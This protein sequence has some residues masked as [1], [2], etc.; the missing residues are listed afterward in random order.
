M[1]DSNIVASVLV[2]SLLPSLWLLHINVGE[3]RARPGRSPAFAAQVAA[4]VFN[5]VNQTIF[6]VLH[7]AKAASLPGSCGAWILI[8]DTSYVLFQPAATGVLVL[9]STALIPSHHRVWW[10]SRRGVRAMLALVF[11]IG[12]SPIVVSVAMRD[13][14]VDSATGLCFALYPL[15]INTAGKIVFVLLYMA[16]GVVF[17]LPLLRHLNA[18]QR[19]SNTGP[20]AT[21]T[22]LRRVL[23]DVAFRISL[24]IVGYLLTAVIS[25][26]GGFTGAVSVEF[27]LQNLCALGAATFA[28]RS[29]NYDSSGGG[30]NGTNTG[31]GPSETNS[32]RPLDSSTVGAGSSTFDDPAR[33]RHGH[34]RAGGA[35]NGSSAGLIS[36]PGYYSMTSSQGMPLTPLSGGH[37]VLVAPEVKSPAL[38][39][40]ALASPAAHAHQGWR[41]PQPPQHHQGVIP[42]APPSP[43]PAS[44]SLS[45]GRTSPWRTSPSPSRG[46]LLEAPAPTARSGLPPPPPLIGAAPPPRRKS[47]APSNTSTSH[48]SK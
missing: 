8:A 9:R 40:P 22:I 11:L 1:W 48:L 27:T 20:A 44:P 32:R 12:L 28:V 19:V 42:P 43:A 15:T 18:M 35:S 30:S 24:A 31:A 2:A 17:A 34:A 39:A 33:Y 14:F 41:G 45:H 38:A 3:W 47:L 36:D 46:P 26:L 23:R 29:R 7:L 10:R 6:V 5:L 37:H 13:V 21:D 4:S 25:L 16:I